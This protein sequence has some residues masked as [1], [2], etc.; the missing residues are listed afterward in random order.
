MIFTFNQTKT[1]YKMKSEF[2]PFPDF[3]YKESIYLNAILLE[4]IFLFHLTSKNK[5]KIWLP[6]DSHPTRFL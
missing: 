4:L 5:S 2:L 1:P 3:F 6:F